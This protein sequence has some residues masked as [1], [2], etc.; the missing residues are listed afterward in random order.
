MQNPTTYQLIKRLLLLWR[1]MLQ[2]P[3]GRMFLVIMAAVMIYQLGLCVG[4]AIGVLVY[5]LNH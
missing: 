1:H 2:N 3:F 5:N 4:E